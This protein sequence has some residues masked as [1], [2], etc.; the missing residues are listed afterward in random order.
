MEKTN[1]LK[2]VTE[3]HMAGDY[4][5]NLTFNDG[6]RCVFDC[7]PLIEQYSMFRPLRDKDVFSCFKLDGWTVTWL[8]GSVDI[9]PEHLYEMGKVA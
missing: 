5:L 7:L 6:H 1:E 8:D 9:A 2:W 4:C 3:A